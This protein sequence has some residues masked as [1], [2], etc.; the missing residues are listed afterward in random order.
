MRSKRGAHKLSGNALRRVIAARNLI[1]LVA[2][3]QRRNSMARRSAATR[4][5]VLYNR[6]ATWLTPSSTWLCCAGGQA[7]T[8]HV[9]VA[10]LAAQEDHINGDFSGVPKMVQDAGGVFV[11]M[12][13]EIGIGIATA[14]DV[15]FG[16]KL[17][18]ADSRLHAVGY[19]SQ[20]LRRLMPA[21]RFD[22]GSVA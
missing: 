15:G 17:V 18:A 11:A 2:C 9:D 22:D 7:A 13:G 19:S 1:R 5:L 20:R 3:D 14:K 4:W 8:W 21:L 16:S 10:S 6:S 12:Y